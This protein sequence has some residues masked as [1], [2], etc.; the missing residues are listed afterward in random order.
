MTAA[1]LATLIY[2]FL[3]AIG[4]IIG[5]VKANSQVSLISGL[6]SGL[7]L[8]ACGFLQ[9]RGLAWATP[10]AFAIAVLLVIT[11]VV[12]LVK[13]GSFMPAG[14]MVIAGT[15]TAIILLLKLS[16]TLAP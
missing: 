12:R 13:T 4:G 5:Y 14:L 2:G 16:R 1:T 8:L 6:V 9:L 3:C 7:L 11:F 15:A 10:A